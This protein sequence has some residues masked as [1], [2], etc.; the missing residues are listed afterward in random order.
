MWKYSIKKHEKW[1]WKGPFNN[2]NCNNTPSDLGSLGSNLDLIFKCIS[3]KGYWYNQ[4]HIV[5]ELEFI[6]MKPPNIGM[7]IKTFYWLQKP[8]RQFPLKA[9]FSPNHNVTFINGSYIA[10]MVW[11]QIKPRGSTVAWSNLN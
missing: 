4:I 5:K 9:P 7:T 1:C 10:T 3:F 6:S 11:D 2:Q 8:R